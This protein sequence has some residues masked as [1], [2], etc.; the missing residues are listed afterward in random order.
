MNVE[1][2]ARQAISRI[3]ETWGLPERGFIAG[4]SISNI[5]WEIGRA[6]V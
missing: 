1:S 5:I 6:H 2:L 3:K 4:G